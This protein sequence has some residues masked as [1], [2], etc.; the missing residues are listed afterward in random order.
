M[1]SALSQ[2]ADYNR[3]LREGVMDTADQAAMHQMADTEAA[4]IMQRQQARPGLQLFAADGTVLC[5]E[6]E[7]PIPP[8]RLRLHPQSS[9]CVDCLGEIE[10]RRKLRREDA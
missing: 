9:F 2:F 3:D 7:A 8:E 4:L 5:L 6:C 1:T 10:L